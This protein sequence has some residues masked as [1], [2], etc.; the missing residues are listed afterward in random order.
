M[1]I[2]F[3]ILLTIVIA[4]LGYRFYRINIHI[5]GD[6]FAPQEEILANR[7]HAGQYE[8]IF[9]KE[10]FNQ[11]QEVYFSDSL[12]SLPLDGNNLPIHSPKII[13]QDLPPDRRYYFCVRKKDNSQ[14]IISERQITLRGAENFRDLGGYQNRDGLFVKWGKCYRSDKLSSLKKQDFKYLNDLN[15]KVICDF[16]G[17]EEVKRHP[18]H[19]PATFQPQL[20]KL[21]IYD[22]RRTLKELI[23][24]LRKADPKS[25]SG[26]DYMIDGYK[27]FSKQFIGRYKQLFE[28]LLENRDGSIVFHCT[29]GKDR[30]GLAS[31]LILYVLDVPWELIYQDYLSSNYYRYEEN[32]RNIRLGKL[33]GIAPEILVPILEVRKVYLDTALETINQSFG[34]IDMLLE[35]ELGVGEGEK[36]ALKAKYLDHK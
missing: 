35:K 6:E 4:W 28:V 23:K 31:A 15:L 25:F 29:G 32:I 3:I 18:N 5:A 19:F 1:G 9:T 30:T 22:P 8:I 11:V 12:E 27:M 7:L 20:I 33:Y 14:R 17:P 36:K 26:E 24:L 10:L 21:P 16:R 13:T 34:S 2:T